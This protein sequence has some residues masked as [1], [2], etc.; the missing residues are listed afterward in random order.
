MIVDAMFEVGGSR[1]FWLNF[2]G[3]APVLVIGGYQAE[4]AY[5]LCEL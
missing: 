3:M 5:L 1:E 4:Q 2:V